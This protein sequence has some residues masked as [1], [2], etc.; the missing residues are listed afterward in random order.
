MSPPAIPKPLDCSEPY[1]SNTDIN[2]HPHGLLSPGPPLVPGIFGVLCEAA[3]LHRTV[4]IYNN[5]VQ[6]GRTGNADDMDGR[7]GLFSKIAALE[8]SLYPRM[9]HYVNL[10]PQTLY[11][12]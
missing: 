8:D 11:L 5:K 10:T 6:P 2:G 4:M 12:K 1:A 9:R 7:R 3:L